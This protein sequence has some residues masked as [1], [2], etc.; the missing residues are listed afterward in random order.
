M[1][2]GNPISLTDNVASKIIRVIATSNQTVFTVDGGYR[3]NQIAVFRNG[4]RL[5]NNSDFTAVDGVTVTI[6]NPTLEGDEVLF[7][8][9]DDFKVANAIVSTASTQTIFGNL[10]INGELHVSSIS[11]GILTTGGDGSQLSGVVNSVIAGDNI[12]VSSATGDVTI[13]GL[14]K[15][16]NINADSLVVTGISTLGIVTGATYYGDGSNLT[17]LPAVTVSETP[18]TLP[19]E[20]DLWWDSSNTVGTL[21]VWYEDGDS[22]Q[23]VEASPA[24][25]DNLY[26]NRIGTNLSPVNLGD[27]IGIGT[28]NPSSN[29]DVEAA[30][31]DA[32]LRIHA[33]ENNSGSEP[34]LILESSN[35]FAESAIDFKDSSGIAGAIRYNHGD[36]ALRFLGKGINGEAMRIDSSGRLLV[37]TSSSSIETTLKLQGNSN[38]STSDAKLQICRGSTSPNDNQFI[39]SIYFS[40]SSELSSASLI[41]ARDGGTWSGSSK[42]SRLT[43]STTADGTTNSTQR[44]RIDSTGKVIISADA[45][46]PNGLFIPHNTQSARYTT[47]EVTG[48]SLSNY[49]MIRAAGKNL[50]RSE[51][52]RNIDLV[53]SATVGTNINVMV[54]VTF[55][56]N[57]S[58]TPLAGV[59]VTRAGYYKTGGANYTFWTNTP[60]VTMYNGSGYGA[61]TVS[62]VGGD[63]NV[64]ILRYGTDSNTNYTNY[65]VKELVV[66]GYDY[67]N[68][69]IL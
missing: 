67:A 27:S 66:T 31:G 58:T 45:I 1:A 6:V 21:F 59:V 3:I 4:V 19:T 42:P 24:G 22:D 2:I 54:E 50:V 13:T 52:E 32:T 35:D 46:A 14:A 60:T 55:Y 10:S 53:Q 51:A 11:A 62:W 65:M 61:G 63:A 8:I 40:D 23:W 7:E 47:L 57:S 12:L 5:S 49:R 15:T 25:N 41:C 68:A 56:L 43:F 44:M 18:P 48:A 30:T 16:D 69:T 36:N 37:G 29:L 64:K 39:G 9:I 34:T 38:S 26:W 28:D 33:A 20:G 17:G